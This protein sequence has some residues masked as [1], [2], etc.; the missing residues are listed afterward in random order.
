MAVRYYSIT[1][2]FTLGEWVHQELWN[3]KEL[4]EHWHGTWLLITNTNQIFTLAMRL[5]IINNLNAELLAILHQLQI[6]WSL[7]I[8]NHNL[9]FFN[10]LIAI[11]LVNETGRNQCVDFFNKKVTS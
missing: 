8:H 11:K 7:G 1:Q 4:N 3:D 5:V 10:S 2:L 6:S 9:I